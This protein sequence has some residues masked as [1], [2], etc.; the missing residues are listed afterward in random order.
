M[1]HA[2]YSVPVV[3]PHASPVASYPTP[4]TAYSFSAAEAFVQALY[5]P[6]VLLVVPAY[7]SVVFAWMAWMVLRNV[8]G[9]SGVD[10]ALPSHGWQKWPAGGAAG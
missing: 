9:H 6:V 7:Q 1:H 5:L 2:G 4:W 10:A 3:P 8:M